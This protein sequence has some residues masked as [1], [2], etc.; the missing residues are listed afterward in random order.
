MPWFLYP[1][2]T[3]NFTMS[4]GNAK[5]QTDFSDSARCLLAGFQFAPIQIHAAGLLEDEQARFSVG[6]G[7]RPD[8]R[9]GFARLV[10]LDGRDIAER[11]PL[12][13]ERPLGAGGHDA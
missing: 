12:R 10:L 5:D 4:G 9:H 6:I 8:A 7:G 13:E 11:Q 3:A 2:P 1:P